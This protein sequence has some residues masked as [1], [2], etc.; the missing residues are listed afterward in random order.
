MAEPYTPPVD[1]GV[2]PPRAADASTRRSVFV[3]I[4]AVLSAFLASLCCIGP[5][6]FVTL[7]VG[8]GLATSFE[9][10]R[11]LFTVATLGV[12]ALGFY[13][14]YG[15]GRAPT[16]YGPASRS[17]GA[18]ARG[19][20]CGIDGR[21]IRPRNRTRDRIILWIGTALALLLLTFPEWSKLLV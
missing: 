15:R 13:V 11:P 2:S 18:P 1:S 10:L 12:L 17:T 20:A 9:P 5:I 6:L 3:S 7:G 21:C 16:I 8:A 4:G 19:P 14:A